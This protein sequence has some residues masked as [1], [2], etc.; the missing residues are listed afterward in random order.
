MT[1][2]P[3]RIAVRWIEHAFR[4]DPALP[5]VLGDLHEDFVHIA[6]E[7]GSGAARRWYVTEAF[8]L[9]ASRTLQTAITALTGPSTMTE[10]FNLRGLKQDIGYA[11]RSIRRSPGFSI[12]TATVIGLGVGATTAVF[13]VIKPLLIAPLPFEDPGRLTWI[14]LNGGSGESLSAVTSRTSNVRDFRAMAQSYEGITAFNAFSGQEAY[15]LEADGQL[16][17]IVGYGVAGDFL[18]VLGVRPAF[19]RTFVE[20]EYSWDGPAAILLSHAFFQQRFGGDST[21]VGRTVS[22]NGT[23][24]EVVGVL[25]AAFDFGSLFTP[26]EQVD[27]LRV[28]E[29]SDRTDNW[30]NTV[31]M[32]GRLR[33]GVTPETAQAELDAIVA[34]LKAEQP[35]RWGL[36]AHIT[37]LQEKISAPVRSGLYLLMAA[38]ATVLLIVCVNVSNMLLARTPGRARE[39][40]VRKALGASRGRLLRQLMVESLAIAAVG[41]VAGAG[42]AWGVTRLVAGTAGIRVPLLDQVGVD[43]LALAFAAGVSILTGLIVG[44]APALQVSEGDEATVLRSGGRG[45]SSSRGARRLRES[46]VIAEV[47]LASVLLVA[48]GLMIR[49]FQAVMDV[50]L[51][52]DPEGAIAWQLNPSGDYETNGEFVSFFSA[53]TDRVGALPGVEAVGLIDALPLGRNRSWG[54]RVVGQP[55]LDLDGIDMHPHIVDP[56]YLEAMRTPLRSGRYLNRNDVEGSAHAVVINTTGA[57]LLFDGQPAIGNYLQLGQAEPWE[58]VGVVDDVRH[59]SPESD[60]GIQVY[61]TMSQMPDYGSIE[62]VVRSSLPLTGAV[63]SVRTALA[64]V[65]PNM[66]TQEFWTMNDAVARAVSA[67]RFLLQV[68]GAFGGA[69]LLLAGLGIYGVLAYS[70][71]ERRAEIGIRMALGASAGTVLKNVIGRTVV[72]AS[73]GIGLGLIVSLGVARLLGSLLFEVGTTDPVTLAGMTTVLLLVALCAGA[74]PAMR[75]ARL[76]GV[77]ALRSE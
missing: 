30:G 27:F 42:I 53:V 55:D 43:G 77:R 60:A 22:L 28:W 46:L 63:S 15:T 38:A 50:E 34:N 21:V 19:G 74:V 10:I 62:M 44:L 49:S 51:G 58:I 73:A 13:S 66:P 2:R 35:D 68:L 26:A 31:H 57:R 3:P 18:D 4:D 41:S 61:F 64:A 8:G 33:P 48:G 12:L 6:R 23:A 5:S 37:P 56:G 69:A 76:N 32:I 67:R 70:V 75:A 17:R 59:I 71:A 29:I 25:P 39:I 1:H 40:A 14:A 54:F 65:D 36:G 7:K 9:F 72:L 52:F 45:A 24:V 20:A 16:Q 11:W 47:A